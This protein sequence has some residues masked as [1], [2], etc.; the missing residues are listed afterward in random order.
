VSKFEEWKGRLFCGQAPGDAYPPYVTAYSSSDTKPSTL[1][2][3][4]IVKRNVDTDH[5]WAT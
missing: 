5:V 2:S 1:V 3:R 4:L